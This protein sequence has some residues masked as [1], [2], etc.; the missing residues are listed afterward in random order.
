MIT[1]YLHHIRFDWPWVLWLLL[2]VPLW[3]RWAWRRRR[4][5]QSSFKH[6]HLAWVP[7]R[8]NWRSRLAATPLVLQALAMACLLVALAKPAH[9]EAIEITDG[10]GIDIVLCLDVSGSM[11][12]GD[13]LPNRLSAS[14][15]VARRFVEG[16]KGDRI[17]LVIFSGQSLAL[18]PLTSDREAVLQQLRQVEYGQ[19]EDGTSIG[20]GLASAVARLK[21]AKTA[22]R[23]I[24]LLTDGEDTGGFLFPDAAKQL[25]MQYG[26]KVYTIGVGSNGLAPMPYQTDRGVEM[27]QEQV[28]IDE[29]LLTDIANST[30]GR[31][32]RATNKNALD[33]IYNAI[34]RLEKSNVQSRI[35]NKRTDEYE[36][37]VG[38]AI[39][40][41]LLGVLLEVTVFKIV[42]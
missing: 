14:L 9:Y 17:G 26:M 3:A 6:T 13:F 22:S 16:R 33:S 21:P 27:R 35:F 30:G 12:A 39:V 36:P 34:D 7:A 15:D 5:R 4:R 29:P 41:L 40:L 42:G 31:Y 25:A 2:L 24:I 23:V 8:R 19:L 28:T 20:T 18:C 37:W 10:D 38:A 32:F 1:Q 11:L